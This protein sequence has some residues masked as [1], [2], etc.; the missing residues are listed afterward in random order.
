MKPL[1]QRIRQILESARTNIARSVNTTQVV[2]NWLVGRE[3]VEEEQNGKARAI[4]GD[5]LLEDLS[6]RLTRDFGS[7][8][9][10]QNIRY[11]RQLYQIYPMLIG[12]SKIRHAVRGEMELVEKGHALRSQSWVPGMLHP[13]LS[14]THYRTLLRVDKTE[15]RAFYEIESIK[16]NWGARELERQMD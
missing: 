15:V 9:S 2:A 1:Y 7:G 5:R 10:M 13:N 4:Y 14:W 12:T 6:K 3:I 16:N 11:I 8:Y